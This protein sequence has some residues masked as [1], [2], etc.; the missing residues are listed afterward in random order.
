[1]LFVESFKKKSML[2]KQG[3]PENYLKDRLMLNIALVV[4]GQ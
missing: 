1:V 4:G 2:D 3:H